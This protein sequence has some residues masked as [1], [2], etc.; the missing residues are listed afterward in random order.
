MTTQLPKFLLPFQNEAKGYIL[1]GQVRDVEFSGGTYQVLVIDTKS[2][3]EVWAFLQLD[4]RGQIKDCF[5]SCEH[6]EDNGPCVHIAAAFLRIYNGNSIPLHQRFHDSLWNQ[7]CRLYADRIGD[8]P[9]QLKKTSTGNYSCS[10]VSGKKVFH[11]K[12]KTPEAISRLKVLIEDRSEETEQTSIKFSNLPPEEIELWRQGKPS[13]S[14]R[15]EL[16]FWNDL[17]HWLMQLQDSHSTFK[18]DFAYSQKQIPNQIDISFPELDISFYLSEANLPLIIPALETVPSPLAVHHTSQDEIEKITYLKITGTL[19]INFKQA[20]QSI[21]EKSSKKKS[22][23]NEYILDGWRYVPGDGFYERHSQQLLNQ[24]KLTGDDVA[25]VLS[26]HTKTIQEHIEGTRV[27]TVPVKIA[28][29][30]HFDAEWNLHIT[31]YAFVPGDLTR[32]Y[33]KNFGSW[34]YIDDD[35]FYPVEKSHFEQLE[36]V[37]S[38]QKIPDF[39]RKERVWLNSQEGFHVHLT[40]MESQIT[41]SLS[42]DN[43]LSF[44]RLLHSKEKEGQGRDFG[45]WV[46][47]ASLGFYSKINAY[48]TLPVSSETSI[49]PEQIPFFIRMHRAELEGIPG[50]FNPRCP[51]AKVGLNIDLIDDSSIHITPEY[52]LHQEYR[53]R[54]VRFFDDVVYVADEGF[55]ELSQDFRLPERFAHALHIDGANVPLFLSHDLDNLKEYAFHIDPRLQKPESI[56]LNAQNISNNVEDH[57]NWYSLQSGYQTERGFIPLSDIASAI[58]QKKRFLFHEAGLLD[59]ADRRFDWIRALPKDRLDKRTNTLLLPILEFIRLNSLQEINISDKAPDA[60][61]SRR[62]LRELIEFKVP[63]KPVISDLLSQLRPY[64]HLGVDWL[65][66]LYCHELSGLLC[67]DMGLGKTHQA[68]ALLAAVTNYYKQMPGASPPLFLVICPTSVLYHWQEKLQEF[69][70]SLRVCMFYG[71]GRS[72]EEFHQ[73]KYDLLLTSYGIWRME[74]EHLSDI[75]FEVAIL[76]E[77]QIAKNHHSRVHLS[78]RHINTRM[79]IGLTGTPIENQLRELKALFDLI[80]PGYMPSEADYRELFM[81][82]IEKENDPERKKLLQRFIKP[83]ILRRKKQE[84]LEDLPEKVEEIAHCTLSP[85][86]QRMYNEVVQQSRQSLLENLQDKSTPVPY[87]HIFAIL[88]SLKQIC[89]HPAAFLKKPEDYKRYESGKWD[90][91]VELL[92]EARD[93]QQKVVVFSQY[94]A[95]LDIFE[96]YLNENNIGF[97][98]IRGSTMDRGEQ[99]RRFNRDPTCEVFLGSLQASGLGVDLTSG[100]VVIHYDRWW[101]AARENQATDR[102]HRIGQTRGVEVFKMVT[103]GTF[104]ERID[105]LIAKKAKLMEEVV[106]VDDHRFIKQFDRE[107][108][109]LLLQEVE[110]TKGD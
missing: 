37:I 38:S 20:R 62:L 103:K 75:H 42:N 80:L 2:K 8:D 102:V 68:M 59:L 25:A 58:K 63:S 83:F 22:V 18:V 32:P 27:H 73:H 71:S 104:E 10:S 94:L 56:Q 1:N 33:S 100:S 24:S 54:D 21:K 82:P 46:Y 5:C 6:G 79:G 36:N 105:I 69:M 109:L 77:L 101:N 72:I 49:P 9:E 84:V 61:Q 12:A 34:I 81:K 52:A 43:R 45:P 35:G 110:E 87:I 44:S 28:Y 108:I 91:F 47:I 4:S 29:T 55:T 89:N 85:E 30:L 19:C 57:R 50:F 23:E 92:N 107:E 88:S 86:Q 67:D 40:S 64:Q 51:V 31:G 41:Y 96:A 106:G 11:I 95:M 74:H 66:F 14:L 15:Y 99:V 13:I 17:A 97:A 26:A 65:W 98:S 48:T 16:S 78:L 76:D 53:H 39:L 60:T 93:S 90:L 70:P 3:E 7:L